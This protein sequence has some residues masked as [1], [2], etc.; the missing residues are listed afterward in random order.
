MA[1]ATAR[2]IDSVPKFTAPA[3]WLFSV[4]MLA[5]ASAAAGSGADRELGAYLSGECVTCHRLSGPAAGGIP[6]IAG[7]P[8]GQFVTAMQAYRS[9]QREN[10]AMQVIAGRLDDHEIAALAAYFSSVPGRP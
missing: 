5:P 8:V 1:P 3:V 7:W 4:M 2:S 9:K 10:A 6:R